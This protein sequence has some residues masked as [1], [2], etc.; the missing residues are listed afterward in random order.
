MKK[1]NIDPSDIS[2]YE[3]EEFEDIGK[4]IQIGDAS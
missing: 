3:R 1:L 4:I 2:G